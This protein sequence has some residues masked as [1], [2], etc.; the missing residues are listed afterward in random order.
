MTRRTF[1]EF[2]QNKVGGGGMPMAPDQGGGDPPVTSKINLGDGNNFPP[3]MVSDDPNS[4]F[5]GKNK[6]LAVLIRAFK[7]GG[8]WGWSKD[9]KSGEDKPVKMGSKKLFLTGGA[10]RDHLAGKKPRNME[11]TT[12]ASADEIYHILSQNKFTYVGGQD[13]LQNLPGDTKQVFWTKKQ[14]K[15]GRPYV[16]GVK[17]RGDEFEISV[18]TKQIKTPDGTVLEPGTQTDDAASRDFTINAMSLLLT[19]D[20]GPNK[21]LY[22]FYGGMH[23]LLGGRIAAVGNLEQKL[24]E[25]PKRALRYARMLARYGDPKK[26]PDEEKMAIRN[27]AEMVGKLDPS[28]IMDEFMKGLNHEDQDARQYLRIYKHLGLLNGV[29]PGMQLDTH[30]PKELREIG[31]KYA[32]IAWMMRHYP[33]EQLDQ[34]LSQHHWKPDDTKKITFLVKALQKL[35]DN[36]DEQALEDLVQSYLQS[37]LSARKLKIWATRLGGK[38]ERL[39]DA[40]LAHV[41]APRVRPL[42]DTPDGTQPTDQFTDLQDPFSGDVNMEQAENRKRRLEHENFK[43]LLAHYNPRGV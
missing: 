17:V 10:L 43:K 15:K 33:P 34:V 14:D 11:L 12:N 22:D 5:Y 29:F 9:E 7:K 13:D 30:L 3:L 24:R 26:I 25:D 42:A 20:N 40:F 37:G 41:Q 6:N 1:L 32:P 2:V 36:M 23:H 28:D 31:D 19:N 35:D 39:I 8:N 4:Q 16:F 38:N 27:A 18:F 21:D